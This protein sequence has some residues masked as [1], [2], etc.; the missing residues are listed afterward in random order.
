MQELMRKNYFLIRRTHSIL[1]LIPF[2]GFFLMHMFLNSRTAQSPEQYQWVPDTLDQIPYLWAIEIFGLLLPM[3]A[4]AVLGVWIAVSGDYGGP[5]KVRSFAGNIGYIVQ[6]IT[7]VVLLV[8]VS[9][10]V[11][12]TWW[13][14][15]Q[16]AMAGDEFD[17]YA[18]MNGI[19]QNPLW[20][21][22]YA[23]FVAM[24]AWHF[25]F[26]IYNF[27]YRWGFTTSRASQRAAL[28]LG[29]GLGL[30][31]LIMGYASLWGLSMS[32]WAHYYQNG[33]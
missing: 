17:I 21:G 5:S 29:L 8:M 6:R 12:Q 1:G 27:A 10:H 7:G 11:F 24:A 13:V 15:K 25:G 28:A 19:V 4:H 14:H 33:G 23:L 31:G 2:G 3:L 30:L 16:V 26:G 20:L 9:Y 32:E 18:H 22:L